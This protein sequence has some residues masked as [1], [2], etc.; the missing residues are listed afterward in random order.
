[1]GGALQACL[2]SK[3]SKRAGPGACLPSN[4]KGALGSSRTFSCYRAHGDKDCGKYVYLTHFD[5]QSFDKTDIDKDDCEI[6]VYLKKCTGDSSYTSDKGCSHSNW[7]KRLDREDYLRHSTAAHCKT[8]QAADSGLTQ[9]LEKRPASST[10]LHIRSPGDVNE[11][12]FVFP[13]FSDVS[14]LEGNSKPC[15]SGSPWQA[16]DSHP[17]T[18]VHIRVNHEDVQHLSRR[19]VRKRQ[20]NLRSRLRR[21]YASLTV[22]AHARV[23]TEEA[24]LRPTWKAVIYTLLYH[25]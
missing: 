20:G 13:H 2:P 8:V 4:Q 15:D 6:F 16:C 23:I 19:K 14:W 3:Q 21:K 18:F 24:V 7:P 17:G 25:M 1:M 12:T 22:I 11:K 10:I 9:D 5:E